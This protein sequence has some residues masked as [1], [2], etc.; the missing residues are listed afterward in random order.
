M[1]RHGS[2]YPDIR[3]MR[4]RALLIE[5]LLGLMMEKGFHELKTKEI[6][7]RAG[8]NRVTFY[9]HFSSKEELLS[10]VMD[11]TLNE[12]AAIIDQISAISAPSPTDLFLAVQL[13]VR[14]IKDNAPF[15]KVMLLTLG[16]P[17]FAFRFHERIYQAMYNSYRKAAPVNTKVN[18]ELYIN[19][20]IGGAIGVFTYW[21]KNDLQ[22]SEEEIMEQILMIAESTSRLLL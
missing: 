2:V 5:A 9:D 18:P 6:A 4:T 19:W 3:V 13:S 1:L 14:H 11:G 10:E 20:I 12:Y 22:P 21:L 17:D 7:D 16:V 8:I 15:Y